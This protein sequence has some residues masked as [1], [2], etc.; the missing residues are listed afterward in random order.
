MALKFILRPLAEGLKRSWAKTP[1]IS[2]LRL[3]RKHD[4]LYLPGMR[5]EAF[6]KI[7]LIIIGAQKSGT[8]TLYKY[9]AAQPGIHMSYPFKEPGYFCDWPFIQRYFER[10]RG[11]RIASRQELYRRYMLKGYAGQ[12]VFGEASTYYT[13]GEQSRRQHIP[14]RILEACGPDVKLIYIMRDPIERMRSNYLH[15]IRK[16]YRSGSYEKV[17]SEED[18]L[19]KTGCYHYQLEPYTQ[20]F[21]R[22]NLLLLQ[23]DE[24]RHDRHG[25]I[26]K[27][28]AF[29]G[30]SLSDD[31]RLLEAANVASNRSEFDPEALELPP[32]T[33]ASLRHIFDEDARL[34]YRD[35]GIRP[36]WMN[37]SLRP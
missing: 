27:L 22:K 30:L 9:P 13:I 3:E 6:P 2:P 32:G 17:L 37:A 31:T 7:N 18:I 36:G 16:K 8:T 21:G 23:F 28:Q 34:L 12:G 1:L 35:Y 15:I 10:D 4:M 33:E 11:Y 29:L 20:L 24:L 26:R 19:V 14:Q 25:L 5:R